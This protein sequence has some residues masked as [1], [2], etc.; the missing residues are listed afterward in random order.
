MEFKICHFILNINNKIEYMT[1]YY[2]AFSFNNH[3]LF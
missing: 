2:S 3:Y 1:Y